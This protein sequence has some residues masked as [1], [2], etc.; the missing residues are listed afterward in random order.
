M[1]KISDVGIIIDLAKEGILKSI[2]KS[3]NSILFWT[4]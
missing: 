1:R 4:I 3:T 2:S